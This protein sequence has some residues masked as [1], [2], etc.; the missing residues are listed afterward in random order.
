MTKGAPGW[1]ARKFPISKIWLLERQPMRK[2]VSRLILGS[3]LIAAPAILHYPRVNA[4]TLTGLIPDI[5]AALDVVSRELVGFIPSVARNATAERAAV[6]QNIDWPVAPKLASVNI[7]P[8][9]TVPTPADIT[10]GQAVMQITKAKAVPVGWTGEEQRGLNNGVGYLT[11]QGDLIAQA[12]RTLVNEI[13]TDLAVEASLNASRSYGT[14]GTTP[15]PLTGSGDRFDR[16][17]DAAQ[18]RKILD[19]NGAPVTGRSLIV[20][21]AAG[22]NIRSMYQLTRVNEAGSS[23]TARDGMLMDMVGFAVKESAGIDNA[24]FTKG[25][26]NGSAATNN[27]GYAVGATVITL[28]S[29]GTGTILAGDYITFAGDANQYLVVSG[30]ASVADGGSITLAAPGLRKAIPASATVITTLNSTIGVRNIGFSADA[31]RLAMRAPAIPVQG[32]LA[33]DRMLITDPRS[34]ATFEFSVWPGYRMVRLEVAAAWG[35]KAVKREHI[36]ALLG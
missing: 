9:M 21:T 16:M 29:A 3:T 26:N 2:N 20:N 32:D 24:P 14:F 25:T 8:A 35:V 10:I 7:T 18:T 12:L 31:I 1:M 33:L 23:M 22:A 6:G 15:F 4:N 5:Y 13:E 34:G 27:A 11:I 17:T 19:D 28:G 30:D 36:A